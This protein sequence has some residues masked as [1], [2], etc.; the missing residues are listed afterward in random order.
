MEA[1]SDNESTVDRT[2]DLINALISS[3]LPERTFALESC[4]EE[5]TKHSSH[6]HARYPVIGLLEGG[7]YLEEELHPFEQHNRADV[8][9]V[10]CIFEL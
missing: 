9:K 10:V 3:Q 1:V 2:T 8:E 4:C 6:D 7:H 5:E